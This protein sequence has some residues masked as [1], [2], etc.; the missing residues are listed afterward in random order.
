[1]RKHV[2]AVISSPRKGGNAELLVDEFIKG[3]KA[4]GHEV[5]KLC[6]REKKIAPCLACEACL[7]N[8]GT[9]VQKDDMAEVLEQIIRA[10]MIVLSTPV[11]YYSVC[12]QLKT[13]IDR[14]LA[15][16]SRMKEK[17]F[18]FITTAADAPEKM[19]RT[20]E[21]LQGFVDCIPDSV[22]KGKVYG[23]SFQVGDIKGKPAMK[24][25]YEYGRNC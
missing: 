2:L 23:Q 24:E 17:E 3:A 9:C 10:D 7:R 5:E 16:G 21:D 12:A 8:G 13:M 25:A 11:Y 19:E 14:T 6:L 15:G 20:M 1:M 18:Y 22:V 4:A